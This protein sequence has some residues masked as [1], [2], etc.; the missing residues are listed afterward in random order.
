MNGHLWEWE[1]DLGQCGRVKMDGLCDGKLELL[2]VEP[3]RSPLYANRIIMCD[4]C[5]NLVVLR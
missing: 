4:K 5:K 3:E 2:R 1:A